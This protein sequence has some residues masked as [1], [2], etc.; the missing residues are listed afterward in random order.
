MWGTTLFTAELVAEAERAARDFDVVE[1]A[2]ADYRAAA[3]RDEE[4]GE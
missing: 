4:R 1:R 3:A 2:A